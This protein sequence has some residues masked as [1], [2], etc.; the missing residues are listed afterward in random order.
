MLVPIIKRVPFHLIGDRDLYYSNL[1]STQTLGTNKDNNQESKI[2]VSFVKNVDNMEVEALSKM[3]DEPLFDWHDDN[4]KTPIQQVYKQDLFSREIDLISQMECKLHDVSGFDYTVVDIVDTAAAKCELLL[5]TGDIMV[6]NMDCTNKLIKKNLLFELI[7][8]DKKSAKIV[9]INDRLNEVLLRPNQHPV[10]HEKL[11]AET[12]RISQNPATDELLISSSK[13]KKRGRTSDVDRLKT[14]HVIDA[15]KKEY[16]SSQKA[17]DIFSDQLVHSSTTAAVEP[18]L[19]D[20]Y[21]V[22]LAVLALVNDNIQCKENHGIYLQ[23]MLNLVKSGVEGETHWPMRSLCRSI[24]NMETCIGIKCIEDIRLDH[25]EQVYYCSYS[26]DTIV[27]GDDVYHIRILEN[28]HE[29]H[30][31]WRIT[32]SRPEREFEAPIFT[33]SIRVFFVKKSFVSLTGLF[34]R[35][36]DASYKEK[37]DHY[38]NPRSNKRV[39]ISKP[40]VTVRRDGKI[41]LKMDKLRN[42]MYTHH[43]DKSVLNGKTFNNES[44]RIGLLLEKIVDPQS[45]QHSLFDIIGAYYNGDANNDD[46]KMTF[47]NRFVVILLQFIDT[48]FTY[49]SNG[50]GGGD[51][52]ALCKLLDLSMSYHATATMSNRE[53]SPNKFKEIE[54]SHHGDVNLYSDFKE[55]NLLFLSVFNHFCPPD[56]EFIKEYNE[57]LQMLGL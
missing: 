15:L 46:A 45:L 52:V 3:G 17:S 38:F 27:Q 50:N 51:N 57:G 1:E 13:P 39:K 14:P 22:F 6:D 20:K 36:F 33:D 43:M 30:K 34:Y 48:L 42:F 7:C 37:Y 53:V 24:L 11:I 19:T 49:D 10:S 31:K 40:C 18:V 12:H 23:N 29:R 35:D 26:G 9:A 47:L 55:N 5:D 16:I 4:G 32:K 28:S 2:D 54:E 25:G 41:W 21:K 44:V 56:P 8:Q